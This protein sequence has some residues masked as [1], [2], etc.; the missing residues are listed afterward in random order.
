MRCCL[1]LILVIGL[2]SWYGFEE[3]PTTANGEKW[4]PMGYT[5]ASN[6]H[7]FG[8][9]LKVTN[10]DNGKSVVVRVNDRGGYDRKGRIIDL[11][12]ASFSKIADLNQGLAKVKVEKEQN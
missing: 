10:M 1:S 7:P 2:A 12:Q 5:C 4:N 8:T 6:I 3:G 9:R 11:S